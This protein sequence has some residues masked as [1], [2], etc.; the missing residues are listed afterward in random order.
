[1]SLLSEMRDKLTKSV[2]VSLDINA[3]NDQVIASLLQMVDTNN[4]KYP[5]RSCLLK[6]KINDGEESMF[7]NLASKSH[8]VNPSDD[9][10]AEI[11]SLTNTNAVLA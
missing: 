3:V 4:Q 7:V 8:K 10:M 6:F 2:T 9:L 11:L 5:S 1:M